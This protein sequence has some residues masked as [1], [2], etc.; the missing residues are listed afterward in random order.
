MKNR[1]CSVSDRRSSAA[2]PPFF[3]SEQ[4]LSRCGAV[5][6]SYDS[7]GRAKICP[8][9]CFKARDRNGHEGY[10]HFHISRLHLKELRR[11]RNSQQDPATNNYR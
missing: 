7:F 11:R 8:V 1:S 9:A 10:G 5:A 2:A 4:H 6:A 3:P